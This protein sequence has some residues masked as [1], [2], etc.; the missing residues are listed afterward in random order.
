M[1]ECLHYKFVH[2]RKGYKDDGT[3]LVQLRV[4]LRRK[5]RYFS[6]GI[7]VKEGQWEQSKYVVKHPQKVIF[8][9]QLRE[10]TGKLETIFICVSQQEKLCLLT[11]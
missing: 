1:N 4:T 6:T 10:I 11:I 8:N 9:N 3:A 7:N 5:T 2:A